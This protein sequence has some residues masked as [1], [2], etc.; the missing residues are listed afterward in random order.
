MNDENKGIAMDEVSEKDNLS[1]TLPEKDIANTIDSN[2]ES[3]SKDGT[4][5]AENSDSISTSKENETPIFVKSNCSLSL[6]EIVPNLYDEVKKAIIQKA[7][8]RE[9]KLKEWFSA[10][11]V[12]D[13]PWA[14]EEQT[15][16]GNKIII[17][18]GKEPKDIWYIGDLHGDILALESAISYI[19][20][21]NSAAHIVFLGDVIDRQEFGFEVA[22]KILELTINNPGKILWIA[23][24]HDIGLKYDSATDKF[25]SAVEPA[26]FS[27]WLNKKTNFSDFG[28]LFIDVVQRL[29]RAMFMQDG[30]CVIHGGVPGKE[31]IINI[32]A[33]GDLSSN[34]ALDAYTFNRINP[35]KPRARGRELG[36][37]NVK[38]FCDKASQ[39][40]GFPVKRL[41]RGHDHCEKDRHLFYEQYKDNPVLTFVTLTTWT[42]DELFFKNLYKCINTSLIVA[43]HRENHLPEIIDIS[44]PRELIESFYGKSSFDEQI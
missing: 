21:Q 4:I 28:R 24:N 41:L 7:L 25:V 10:H 20:K 31:Q 43:H 42:P 8:G 17:D 26:E 30:L 15:R 16:T 18:D 27:H 1:G 19:Q 2:V 39:L 14:W 11:R 33:I 5:S 32:N 37:E 34:I 36:W 9:Q 6:Y 35:E 3:E 12:E 40:L 29:P 13:L 44:I 23:G 22:T 38:L